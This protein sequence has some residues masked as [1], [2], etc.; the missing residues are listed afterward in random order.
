MSFLG[1][2]LLCSFV[3]VSEIFRGESFET[4]VIL[5]A[6]SLP[7]RAPVASSMFWIAL[8]EAVSIEPFAN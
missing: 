8:F 2:S 5:S 7:I 1:I 6:I 4:S 3:T